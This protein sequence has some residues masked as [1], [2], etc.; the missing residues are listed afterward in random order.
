MRHV[1]VAFLITITLVFPSNSQQRYFYKGRNYGSEALYNP[2][3]LLL[4]DSYD[5]LQIQNHNRK[6]FEFNYAAGAKNVFKNLAN[7]FGV[8]SRSSIKD[9]ISSQ[10][11][12]IELTRKGAQWWPNYQLHLIGGGMNCAAI[13]EWYEEK[14]FPIPALLSYLTIGSFDL[15][16]EIV[17]NGNF[18]GDNVD[19]IADL[20]IFDLGGMIL[21]SFEGVKRFFSQELNLSDWSLQPSFIFGKNELHNS[22][23]YFS[24]KWKF[25]FSSKWHLFYYFGMNGLTGLSYKFEDGSAIS[26]GAGLRAKQFE[27]LDQTMNKKTITLTWNAGVFYD[28][29][30]SLMTSLHVSGLTDYT[31]NLNI[32]PGIICI[33]NFSPGIWTV[34]QKDGKV[35]LGITTIY[36]PG[37]GITW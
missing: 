33:G 20:Y 1:L 18:V 11:L 37:L 23:Q 7:P 22:G 9:F 25:P 32:Y 12:P 14:N 24:I 36:A 26:V 30:N 8:I 3:Y 15:L 34:L 5:I 4:N 10:L 13:K 21:F 2:I 27:V 6:I 35:I 28:L 29:N 16:N 19:P 17:E 31:I